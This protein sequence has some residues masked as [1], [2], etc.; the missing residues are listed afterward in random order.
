MSYYP[1]LPQQLD[2]PSNNTAHLR[3]K[4]K[5]APVFQ[6]INTHLSRF[7][8]EHHSNKNL[9]RA[10]KRGNFASQKSFSCDYPSPSKP[11]NL[12]ENSIN[13]SETFE[14]AYL[15]DGSVLEKSSDERIGPANS[16][17]G[18]QLGEIEIL[19]YIEIGFVL[20]LN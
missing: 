2:A 12:F 15:F 18:N 13:A 9:D 8:K 11:D 6:D 19:L 16:H 4:T 7:K 10:Q 17:Y 3:P 1:H 14:Q 5:N 20:C